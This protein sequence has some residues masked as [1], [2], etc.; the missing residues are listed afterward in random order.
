M[1]LN[2]VHCRKSEISIEVEPL[3]SFQDT[4]T[5]KFEVRGERN[6]SDTTFFVTKDQANQII[7]DL[8]R[9]MSEINTESL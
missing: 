8:V 9:K 7:N 2:S 5:I 4:L 6:S 3:P 1:N